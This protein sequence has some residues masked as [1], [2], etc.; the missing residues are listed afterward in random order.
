MWHFLKE[1][2]R[3]DTTNVNLS[4][5]HLAIEEKKEQFL[6]YLAKTSYCLNNKVLDNLLEHLI[7]VF[8]FRGS[9]NQRGAS[10]FRETKS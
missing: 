2:L 4:A 3:T 10:A 1:L 5:F 8:D 6:L 7:F 9:K